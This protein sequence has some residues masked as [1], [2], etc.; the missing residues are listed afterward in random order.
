MLSVAAAGDQELPYDGIASLTGLDYN[1]AIYQVAQLA[2]GRG[3]QP[4][5]RLL[6]LS[7][8]DRSRKR[9]VSLAED[10]WN[11]ARIFVSDEE[12]QDGAGIA[13]AIRQGPLQAV[14][15]ASEEMPGISLGTLTVL[16]FVAQLQ[17]SFGFDGLAARTLEG[18]LGISNLPRHLS[19]L[20]EG[21]DGKPGY[22]VLSLLPH[23]TDKRVKLPELTE[24][25]HQLVSRIAAAV[26]GENLVAPLRPRPEKLDALD[27]PGEI[28]WLGPEDYEPVVP[29]A[30]KAGAGGKE[31][32]S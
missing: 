24:R 18:K 15:I 8:L 12:Q 17:R 5:L 13:D 30:G 21:S 14:Q 28:Q 10:G 9:G 3:G 11:L 19:A 31:E 20:A 2:D 27:D 7:P 16:L 22:G 6:A 25:G 26:I 23:A 1:A 29:P 4:G 32:L